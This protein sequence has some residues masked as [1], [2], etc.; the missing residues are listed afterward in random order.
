MQTKLDM[1]NIQH[2]SATDGLFPF[3]ELDE[4]KK[5][6]LKASNKKGW[7]H[8]L[9]C[10][11]NNKKRKWKWNFGMS[12][13]RRKKGTTVDILENLFVEYDSDL[14]DKLWKKKV[15]DPDGTKKISDDLTYFMPQIV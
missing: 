3:D 11:F 14:V 9:M 1:D 4:K 6:I 7:F 12:M 5:L 13:K 2:R 15:Y 8:F 10:C